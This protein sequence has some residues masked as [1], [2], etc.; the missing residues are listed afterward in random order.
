MMTAGNRL[1][2]TNLVFIILNPFIMR[3]LHKVTI[4]VI[5]IIMGGSV[6]FT[7]YAHG[8]EPHGE[9]AAQGAA[10]PI[11]T[12]VQP[13]DGGQGG[14]IDA[15]G[16]VLAKHAS[17]IFSARNG[18]VDAVLVD[19]GDNVRAGQVVAR[20]TPD[21]EQMKLQADLTAEEAQIKALENQ[22]NILK[23]TQTLHIDKL[24]TSEQFSLQTKRSSVDARLQSLAA[25]Q[26][27]LD[28]ARA[29]TPATQAEV[30][31]NIARI[32]AAIDAAK[33]S[34]QNDE[35]AVEK[36]IGELV[37]E[38]SR[39]LFTE[40]NVLAQPGSSPSQYIRF[41]FATRTN[42]T[43]IFSND[44]A[45]FYQD[46]LK[47]E[48]NAE[49]S[50]DAL[51][52]LV[53][54]GTSLGRRMR[55]LLDGAITSSTFSTSDIYDLRSDVSTTL[56]HLISVDATRI[57]NA[58]TV[59]TLTAERKQVAAASEQRTAQ[60]NGQ[61]KTLEAKLAA[62]RAEQDIA[63]TERGAAAMQ[64][65]Q[66][67]AITEAE[68]EK[69]LAQIDIELSVKRANRD[70]L[71]AQVSIGR[72]VRAPFDGSITARH[73]SPGNSVDQSKALF[74]VVNK[75]TSFV[76]FYVSDVD[77][78]LIAVGTEVDISH[79]SKSV[80]VK[81]RVSRVAPAI[82]EATRLVLVEA[83]I[84]TAD[85]DA[86]PIRGTVRVRAQ[87]L[88]DAGQLVIPAAALGLGDGSAVWVVN[89]KVETVRKPVTV[90][91]VRDGKAYITD[92]ITAHDWIVIKSPV[93]LTD[94]LKVDTT[95]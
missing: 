15:A 19:V 7:A 6:A 57:E 33:K 83:D 30:E 28:A 39:A 87:L 58:N 12:V 40:P 38:L 41:I 21:I 52:R 49:N 90:S 51:T 74:G 54:T 25:I 72:D 24:V 29:A 65:S 70:R 14:A 91:L 71:A 67:I 13:T 35:R 3:I 45:V 68:L 78:G 5:I 80:P 92:G 32:D 34:R 69:E 62:T 61:I 23:R 73:V 59:A 82:D 79:P 44:L 11:V 8:G 17:E 85:T 37:N 9:T 43:T 50:N 93:S 89:D 56:D 10:Y 36:A 63:V 16:I 88:A 60:T 53:T 95:N 22:K 75:S 42:D 76:R 66:D 86:L 47:Y 81:A 2:D 48:A 77:A 1:I 27:E 20:L 55:I 31:A 84:P 18:I 46:Y 4:V 94:N 26:A 64:A